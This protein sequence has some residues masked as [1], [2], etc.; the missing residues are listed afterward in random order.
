MTEEDKKTIVEQMAKAIEDFN[1][2]Q[3]EYEHQLIIKACSENNFIVPS[4]EVKETLE[5]FLPEGT[6]IIVSHFTTD[7]LMIK[8]CV[9]E[10]PYIDP[11]SIKIEVDE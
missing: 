4:V 1:R 10:F 5:K 3:A 11:Q 6:R 9:L 8:K 7:V 2:K